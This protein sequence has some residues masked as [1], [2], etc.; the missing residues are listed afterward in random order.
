MTNRD[1]RED[2]AVIALC[3]LACGLFWAL[4][5]LMAISGGTA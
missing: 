5:G 2:P 1:D 3:C 4:L